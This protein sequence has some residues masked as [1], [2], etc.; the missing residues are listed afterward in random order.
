MDASDIS[1][2][3]QKICKSL[4]EEYDSGNNFEYFQSFDGYLKKNNII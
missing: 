3:F 1:N 4:S 2:N